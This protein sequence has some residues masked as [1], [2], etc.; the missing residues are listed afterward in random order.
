MYLKKSVSL[1]LAVIFALSLCVSSVAQPLSRPETGILGTGTVSLPR[2]LSGNSQSLLNPQEQQAYQRIFNSLEN[3]ETSISLYDLQISVESFIRIYFTVLEDHPE[4]F[5]ISMC[6]Y[7]YEQESLLVVEALPIYYQYDKPLAD[8]VSFV[9]QETR[10][11]LSTVNSSLTD[12]EKALV[13]HDYLASHFSYDL[14]YSISEIYGF[15]SKKTGVCQ[16]YTNL[17]KYLMRSLGVETSSVTSTAMNHTW[18]IVKIDGQWYHVD[19]TWDDP[20]ANSEYYGLANHNNFLLSDEG[21]RATGH[22]DWEYDSLYIAGSCDDTRYENAY[23]TEGITSPIVY[24]NGKWYFVSLGGLYCSENR[25]EPLVSILN[26]N[27]GEGSYWTSAYAGL[28]VRG[29]VLYFNTS[30]SLCSYDT[31]S[32]DFRKL[33]TLEED[34]KQIF[35]MTMAG[36]TVTYAVG[37]TPGYSLDKRMFTIPRGKPSVGDV[38]GDGEVNAA[39]GMLFAR[40]MAKWSV[41][42][43]DMSAADINRDGEIN[44]ADSALLARYLAKW[45]IAYF[46]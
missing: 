14:S 25:T 9:K 18:N 35:G 1:L 46:D 39:D 27:A 37:P 36:S 30:D 23:W 11:I 32:G 7:S 29:N 43:K 21:I 44:S 20:V 16:A 3:L 19:V 42:L 13:V 22:Y 5:Y 28:S 2:S 12:V 45:D 10:E 33:Y 34:G 24:C 4:L 41:T 38:N 17:Y 6:S 26:W 31:V 40:Y 15:L 8:V